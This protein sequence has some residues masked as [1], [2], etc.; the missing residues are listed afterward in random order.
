MVRVKDPHVLNHHGCSR[1]SYVPTGSRSSSRFGAERRAH[2]DGY[3]P[4]CARHCDN[5][6]RD[7]Y[8]AHSATRRERHSGV[9]LVSDGVVVGTFVERRKSA[10]WVRRELLHQQHLLDEC[11]QWNLCVSHERNVELHGD[12]VAERL[13]CVL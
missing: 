7:G 13:E 9:E 4:W 2:R 3:S 11:H 6:E 8:G 5:C 10:H 1:V 12:W